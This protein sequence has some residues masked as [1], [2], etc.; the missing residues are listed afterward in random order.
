MNENFASKTLLTDEDV[1]LTDAR[2]AFREEINPEAYRIFL[3][4][5]FDP[6]IR[7]IRRIARGVYK[8]VDFLANLL[9]RTWQRSAMLAAPQTRRSIPLPFWLY[10]LL[11]ESILLLLDF[12]ISAI[13]SEFHGIRINIIPLEFFNVLI[14]FCFIV[15]VKAYFD[16]LRDEIRFDLI[17]YVTS[18]K[19]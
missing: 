4:I 16:K 14:S 6:V 12:S 9:M 3:D 8:F 7:I 11:F 15:L 2:T 13:V 10:V 18:I 5:M 1:N 17:D 19:S